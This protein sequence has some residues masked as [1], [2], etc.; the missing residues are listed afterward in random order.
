[1]V[2]CLCLINR[3]FVIFAHSLAATT[4][5]MRLTLSEV[6]EL[7]GPT[8]A[9]SSTPWN[10][11]YMYVS[12]FNSFHYYLDGIFKSWMLQTLTHRATWTSGDFPSPPSAIAVSLQ[13]PIKTHFAFLFYIFEQ[14]KNWNTVYQTCIACYFH[15]PSCS[16]P[17]MPEP[18]A[19]LA[20]SAIDTSLLDIYHWKSECESES[21]V[22][23][24]T[25]LG[26]RVHAWRLWT[27]H[28]TV[29]LS[30]MKA[31]TRDE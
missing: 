1:M 20:S 26:L 10:I 6:V 27:C 2:A 29:V 14:T 31:W 24:L 4:D 19:P 5:L 7:G 11:W 16:Q 8:L 17:Y 15:A 13:R 30:G 9:N 12:Q 25:I 3:L 18:S 22:Y 28:P 21:R 23:S